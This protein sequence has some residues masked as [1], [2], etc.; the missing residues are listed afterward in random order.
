MTL[1]F[2]FSI[3]TILI[4]QR[5]SFFAFLRSG[6]FLA[7]EKWRCSYTCKWLLGGYSIFT[8]LGGFESILYT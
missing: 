2:W 8:L 6:Y 4:C 7:S 1:H 3:M 5:K